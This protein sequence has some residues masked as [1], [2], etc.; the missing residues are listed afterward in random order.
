MLVVIFWVVM[1]CGLI[2]GYQCFCDLLF[3]IGL[4]DLSFNVTDKGSGPCRRRLV[5]EADRLASTKPVVRYAI[6]L[7]RYIHFSVYCNTKNNW[8]T[9]KVLSLQKSHCRVLKIFNFK[10]EFSTG[11]SK[12]TN[13]VQAFA[14]CI[15]CEALN[16]C[17]LIINFSS[18]L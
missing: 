14:K 15:H 2:K 16:R 3:R 6:D 13:V 8:K 9:S 1:P 11:M 17:I 4:E 7:L 10:Q 18:P 12:H 5:C